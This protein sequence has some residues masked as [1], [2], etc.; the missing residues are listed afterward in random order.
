MGFN[1]LFFCALIALYQWSVHTPGS[2][3]GIKF[4]TCYAL[5]SAFLLRSIV[6]DGARNDLRR[7]LALIGDFVT[8]SFEIHA[9]GAATAVFSPLYLWVIFGNGFR[10][11]LRYL[12][13]AALI[14]NAGFLV[15]AFTT[16]FWKE[17]LGLTTG[18]SVGLLVLPLY[19]S[20]LIKKLSLATEQAQAASKAKSVFLANVSHDLRTP[21][22]TITSAAAL[23]DATLLDSEQ[24]DL[25]SVLT[26][27]SRHLRS[28]IGDILDLSS[29]EL[30]GRGLEPVAT[31][32]GFILLEAWNLGRLPAA[33]RGIELRMQVDPRLPERILVDR[34]VLQQILMNL[35][36]NAIKFTP[37]GHITLAAL[38]GDR[39]G[40]I[41][42]EVDDTGIGI[43][44]AA[45]GSIFESFVQADATIV[46]RFGGTGLGL[47]IAKQLV[48]GLGGHIGVESTIGQGS[49][50]WFTM[51]IDLPLKAEASTDA[52]ITLGSFLRPVAVLVA[53]GSTSTIEDR[54][55]VAGVEVIVVPTLV[56][57]TARVGVCRAEGR[58]AAIVTPLS[59]GGNADQDTSNLRSLRDSGA[60]F[61]AAT[62]EEVNMT[63]RTHGLRSWIHAGAS[64][65][66]MRAAFRAV[67]SLIAVATADSEKTA[68]PPSSGLR[69]LV[70]DDNRVN[71][72]IMAA[73][74][75]RG[76]HQPVL[77]AHG[78]EALEL[79]EHETF[80][81][82][83]MDVNMPGLSGIDATKAFRFMEAHGAHTPIVALTA[84]ATPEMAVRCK[85]AGM[86]LVLNKPVEPDKVLSIIRGLIEQQ[87]AGS[88]DRTPVAPTRH[89]P[90]FDVVLP[91]I[92]RTMFRSLVDL[93]GEQGEEFA[94]GIY[95]D[96]ADDA[97]LLIPTLRAA[98]E[99][100]DFARFRECGHAIKS[101][102]LNIGASAISEFAHTAEIMS[103]T[104]FLRDGLRVAARLDIELS[105]LRKEIGLSGLAMRREQE[106]PG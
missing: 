87:G 81:L 56:A 86:D 43:A 49:T 84:D 35:L 102:G 47:S 2:A 96:F 94:F 78:M 105:R 27:S 67:S 68:E 54:L 6:V 15:M 70:A 3:L 12:I 97:G 100:N 1:R 45:V 76:G 61:F 50:F 99:A 64:P 14:A 82:V 17:N 77:A 69:I 21:L 20:T 46:D 75:E 19:V 39:T 53:N 23:L 28:L 90:V 72:R 13:R 83:L 5:L 11:G 88:A 63:R 71:C 98:A 52:G 25:L 80:D 79:L 34:G 58:L 73:I 59:S 8:I 38:Q 104:D 66:Q 26:G 103:A 33:E 93:G 9:G 24:K 40:L 32:I 7:T 37:T 60:V 10:F 89:F 106:S 101:S 74:L 65:A 57:A 29:M 4:I 95:S 41:R 51:P 48:L 44:S 91:V 92:D 22:H 31:E 16:V 18:F 85:D 30:N 42:F 62:E 55:G 36:N